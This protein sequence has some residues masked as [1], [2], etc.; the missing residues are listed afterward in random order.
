MS[1]GSSGVA[2]VWAWLWIT[3]GK[4]F[5]GIAAFALEYD[6]LTPEHASAEALASLPLLG[7]SHWDLEPTQGRSTQTIRDCKGLLAAIKSGL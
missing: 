6:T 7:S 3:L 5:R 4:H 2:S 1:S